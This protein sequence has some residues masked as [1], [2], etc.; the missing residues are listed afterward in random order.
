MSFDLL[1]KPGYLEI[2]NGDDNN[3]KNFDTDI[4][5]K[6]VAIG[7]QINYNV[8]IKKIQNGSSTLEKEMKN[9]ENEDQKKDFFFHMILYSEGLYNKLKKEYINDKDFKRYFSVADD[10]KIN[11]NTVSIKSESY[12]DDEPLILENI[13]YY[14]KI[15][16]TE[17]FKDE[18]KDLIKDSLNVDY[19][20]MYE[21]TSSEKGYVSIRYNTS[22]EVDNANEK[23]KVYLKKIYLEKNINLVLDPCQRILTLLKIIEINI[24]D[25]LPILNEFLQNEEDKSK[26]EILL[27]NILH[28]CCKNETKL[29]NVYNELNKGGEM[30]KYNNNSYKENFG[31]EHLKLLDKVCREIILN[32][33]QYTDT[34]TLDMSF[35][36]F[37]HKSEY[38]KNRIRE[39]IKE[40]LRFENVSIIDVCKGS[41]KVKYQ[42][43]FDNKTSTSTKNTFFKSIQDTSTN[44][45]INEYINQNDSNNITVPDIHEIINDTVDVLI[46][47]PSKFDSIRVELK[48]IINN[49][50]II[51]EVMRYVEDEFNNINY[52]SITNT[53]NTNINH[54]EHAIIQEGF[55]KVFYEIVSGN[56]GLDSIYD[57]FIETEIEM[58][59]EEKPYLK[60][61]IEWSNNRIIRLLGIDDNEIMDIRV[62]ND[63]FNRLFAELV[64]CR[65]NLSK[66]FYSYRD[67]QRYSAQY[68]HMLLK[69]EMKRILTSIE[70]DWIKRNKNNNGNKNKRL[71]LWEPCGQ[72]DE[73][74][75]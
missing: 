35:Y 66:E 32:E 38:F 48:E 39:V 41:V 1:L 55:K 69:S 70:R 74:L 16:N 46:K 71:R 8:L 11:K 26:S 40:A 30:E 15:H 18:I 28:V 72:C 7:E 12:D 23:I 58:Y 73:Y 24:G 34:L 50:E 19:V 59:K 5:I 6:T 10:I 21:I 57:L 17:Q 22:P 64:S 67:T 25:R 51:E 61:A 53:T 3:S 20:G 52:N 36:D 14:E 2:I 42:L 45:L 60:S 9:I 4:D 29:K 31:T 63:S 37:F 65:I 54:H 47:D 56:L 13:D 33:I 43:K 75:N 27:N 68:D 44:T 49:S 62:K